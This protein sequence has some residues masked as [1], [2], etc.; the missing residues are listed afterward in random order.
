MGHHRQWR[1]V[2]LCALALA[3]QAQAPPPAQVE[4]AQDKKPTGISTPPIVITGS[5]IPRTN[6]TA[7]SP[8]TMIDQQEIKLEGVT[9]TEELLNQLP[10][11]S[12]D[13]GA[14]VSAG[15]T[16]TATVDLRGLGAARTLVLLNGRR[17]LPGDPAYPAPD[18]NAIPSSLIKRV[19]V[20]TG[21]ASSV[22]GSDAVAGVVNFIIDTRFTGLRFDGQASFFQHDNRVGSPIRDVLVNEG[23]AFPKGN[24]VD[25][26]RR[27]INAAWG[28]SLLGGRG[29]VT[30]YAGYRKL[31]QLTEDKRDYTAC[32]I[33]A[34]DFAPDQLKCGGSPVSFPGNFI[35]N[36]DLFQI[37]PDRT[38]TPGFDPFNFAP[39]NF[40]QR[41]DRR[42]T[43]GGFADLE[44][45]DALNPYLEVMYMDDRSVAQVAPSGNFFGTQDINCDSPLLSDQQRSQ[46]CFDGNFVGQFPIFDDDGNFLGIAGTPTPFTDPVS[47]STY[48][49]GWLFIGR[50]NVEGGPRRDDKRHKNLRLLGGLKGELGRGITYDASY[51]YGRVS[52]NSA[53]TN[54]LSST[55]IRRSLDIVSNPSTGQPVCRS[56][57]T[58]ED[59][60]CVPW[61]IFALGAVTRQAT[62]YLA[63]SAH[64][65]G[66]VSEQVATG[67]VTAQL[68]ERGIRS[69][70]AEEGPA[71]NLG[72][73]YRKD[74]TDFRPDALYQSGDLAGSDP[75][76]PYSGSVRVKELFGE[77]RIPLIEHRFI[78][79][80][81]LEWGYRQ[82]WYSNPENRF[83]TN[84][85]KA[86]LDV[87]PLRGI[88][89]RASHQRAVRAP[90]IVE[91]FAPEFSYQFGNDPCAGVSPHATLEQCE[92]T[93]VTSAQYG[94]ILAIPSDS[95]GYNAR[96]GGNP[97]LE[98]ET[99]TTRTLGLVLEPRF[100]PSFNVT[101]D[102]FDIKLKGAV[103]EIFARTIVDTCIETGDPLF[104][105]RI[106]RDAAGSLWL[107][108]EGYVDDRNA[109]IGSLQVRGIDIGVDYSRKL[110]RFGSVNLR[111]LGSRLQRYVIDNGGLSTP[112]NCAG[113]YGFPCS[114]PFPRWRHTARLTWESQ[115][116]L[117]LSLHWRYIGGTRLASIKYRPD[118]PFS[119]R[120]AKLPAYSYFDVTGLF[121]AG[122]RHVLRF[123]VNNIFDK[124]PPVVTASFAACSNGCNGGTFPQ[125]YDPLGRYVFVGATL[126]FK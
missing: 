100:L 101:I 57:L 82:S 113:F 44:I 24:S 63:L 8:V 69:P 103:G 21:G 22:Y 43:G 123:G 77:A 11:V 73:E 84:S 78:D 83:S 52:F 79:R 7:V 111:F 2:S 85:Y 3:L 67:F 20:L 105:S 121:S 98:P 99:A 30:L 58:G 28:T 66:S 89:L 38:F 75:L 1:G 104:C 56:V 37:G 50:R 72:A 92:R 96:A 54:E 10:M 93:G 88:R 94:N 124:Q 15:A 61:D 102:W 31:S 120:D 33:G 53:F 39:W 95:F 41:P 34:E 122:S 117:S 110:G 71:L 109:N 27:D 45:S 97:F 29:H 126:N 74:Y 76:S 106:H 51:L 60:N 47:G 112:R 90:N 108:Q 42:Y 59:P 115:S 49:R 32:T 55:R 65:S 116:G 68:G 4:S 14:F 91:L 6:L 18:L 62:D 48:N 17:L 81:A 80:L 36:F 86:A 114:L 118:L 125:L 46:V 13:Q 25:G 87:V 26:D 107:S 9:L 119:S 23:L 16:G 19:E 64:R 35:T 40:L 70:W 12:P 5:R